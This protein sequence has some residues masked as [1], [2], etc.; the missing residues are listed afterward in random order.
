M[1][2]RPDSIL[3]TLSQQTIRDYRDGYRGILTA[4]RCSDGENMAWWYRTGNGP[5]QDV[6][7]VYW[8]IAGRIRWRCRLLNLVKDKW[9]Q[10]S[11]R[12]DPMYAKCWLVMI[13][14]EPIPRELQIERKGFQGFRYFDSQK[15]DFT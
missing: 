15:I 11:N 3:V 5:K 2:E 13:D 8:V 10:F 4:W 1:L 9:M 14:F 6:V 12:S 7:W